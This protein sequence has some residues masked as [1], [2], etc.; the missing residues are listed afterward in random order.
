MTSQ[1]VQ[2]KR[3]TLVCSM[4]FLYPASLTNTHWEDNF[5]SQLFFLSRKKN[6]LVCS[7]IFFYPASLKNTH[8]EE[9]FTSQHVKG[10]KK[11][12]LV[13]S[14]IFF[15][16]VSISRFLRCKTGRSEIKVVL[17]RLMTVS[18][19]YCTDCQ[20]RQITLVFHTWKER[21]EKTY[22]TKTE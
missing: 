10:K 16:P 4:F 3:T 17:M 2:K 15:Y 5:T 22:T 6:W 7:M 20:H 21:K 12:T 9:N 13:C 1:L 8:W 14:M 11:S 19:W 18:L